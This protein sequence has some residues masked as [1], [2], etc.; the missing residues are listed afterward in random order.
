MLSILSPAKTLDFDTAP[1]TRKST[2][3]L[4]LDEAATLV[5]AARNMTP[6]DIRSSDGRLRKKSRCST[7]SDS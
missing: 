1:S 5:G 6:D 3:P 7:T 4:F 2:Q